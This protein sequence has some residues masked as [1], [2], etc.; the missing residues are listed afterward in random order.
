MNIDDAINNAI[1]VFLL[2]LLFV[3]VVPTLTLLARSPHA[4]GNY[5]PGAKIEDIQKILEKCNSK[6]ESNNKAH[7]KQY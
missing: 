4:C 7:D 5:Y 3:I 1:G 6:A 2:L